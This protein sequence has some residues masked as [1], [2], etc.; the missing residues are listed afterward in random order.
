M[1]I[2]STCLVALLPGARTPE[3]LLRWCRESGATCV[4]HE[5]APDLE[6]PAV[7]DLC[8]VI[9][10]GGAGRPYDDGIVPTDALGRLLATTVGRQIPTLGVGGGAHFVAWSLGARPGTPD[11]RQPTGLRT[12]TRT[13][14]GRLDVLFSHV[15]SGARWVEWSDVAFT[16]LPVGSEV[17]AVDDAG[18]PQAVRFGPLTWGL[19]GHPYLDREAVSALLAE[20]GPQMPARAR[21]GLAARLDEIDAV[22]DAWRP[23][24]TEFLHLVASGTPGRGG[25]GFIRRRH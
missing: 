9:V 6:P 17:L 23:M 7:H 16:T 4:V 21:A 5:V 14:R 3:K 13:A 10:V 15:P 20:F 12:V 2:V 1:L 24:I 18:L 8:G 25:G 19:Q 22:S 11:T